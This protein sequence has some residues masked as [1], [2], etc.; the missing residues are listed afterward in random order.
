MHRLCQ[1]HAKLGG[2]SMTWMQVHRKPVCERLL[3]HRAAHP[4][5]CE[6]S[7][8]QETLCQVN[9]VLCCFVT[10][11]VGSFGGTRRTRADV[12]QRNANTEH[13]TCDW[14]LY[15]GKQ[16]PSVMSVHRRLQLDKSV[17]KRVH[18]TSAP[19]TL[20]KKQHRLSTH[21]A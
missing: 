20:V 5:I 13:S 4:C 6:G 19:L 9:A 14:R 15:Q 18:P 2:F 16:S 3:P 8:T 21:D 10:V 12:I 7:T 17:R 11:L 1:E